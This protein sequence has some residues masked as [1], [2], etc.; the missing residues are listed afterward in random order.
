MDGLISRAADQFSEGSDFESGVEGLWTWPMMGPSRGEWPITCSLQV[1]IRIASTRRFTCRYDILWFETAQYLYCWLLY[2][3]FVSSVLYQHLI[4]S[5]GSSPC[6]SHV[7]FLLLV[8]YLLA[9]AKTI[10]MHNKSINKPSFSRAYIMCAIDSVQVS[11]WVILRAPFSVVCVC[12]CRQAR[13]A[14]YSKTTKF[15]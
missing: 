13:L 12:L 5:K 14:G 9:H 1:V 11:I 10:T 15:T 4:N 7:E 6:G 3:I 2:Q 8:S